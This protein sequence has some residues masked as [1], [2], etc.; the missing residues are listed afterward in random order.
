M[1]VQL[2][3]CSGAAELSRSLSN[4][5]C[6][7]PKGCGK[8]CGLY[9]GLFSGLIAGVSFGGLGGSGTFEGNNV[10]SPSPADSYSGDV[11][12]DT[13]APGGGNLCCRIQPLLPLRQAGGDHGADERSDSGS[14]SSE[15][16]TE[17]FNE[18]LKVG[19]CP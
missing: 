13:D 12:C 9:S 15:R 7:P 16:K 11:L 4:T 6:P 2:P 18:G 17:L 5:G 19:D 10:S 8:S 1:C 3:A 14:D